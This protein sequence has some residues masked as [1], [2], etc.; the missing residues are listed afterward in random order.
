MN[1]LLAYATNSGSTYTVSELVSNTLSEKGH[2]VDVKNIPEVEHREFGNYDLIIFASPSWDHEGNEGYPHSDFVYF[3]EGVG[4]A[5]YSGKKFA[6]VGLGDSNYEHFCGAVDHLQ[7]FIKKLEGEE[8]VEPVKIDQY[9]MDP[10]THNQ[11]VKDWVEQELLA[12]LG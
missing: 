4:D 9:F 6:I 11:K 10:E 3:M 7:E 12:K 2:Q 1:V 5:K 8:V